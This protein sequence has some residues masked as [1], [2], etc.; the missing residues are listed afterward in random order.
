[1]FDDVLPDISHDVFVAK[2]S[3]DWTMDILCSPMVRY[4]PHRPDTEVDESSR[5]VA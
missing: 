4:V 2:N 1:M 3:F 5:L